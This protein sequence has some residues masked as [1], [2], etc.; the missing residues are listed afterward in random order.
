MKSLV[1]GAGYAGLSAATALVAAGRDVTVLEARDRVGGRAWSQRL[2]NGAVI[3]R[4]AEFIFPGE[5]TIRQ[6]AAEYRVPVLSHGVLYERRTLN[7][8][9]VSWDQLLEDEHLVLDTAQ[10]LAAD[11][12][13]SVEDAFKAA[14]GDGY[15]QNSYFRRY[16]TSASADPALV[17]VHSLL[18]PTS[19]PLIEDG[20]HMLGGNQALAIAMAA[21]LGERVHLSTPV[22]SI[23]LSSDQVS[24][25]TASGNRFS[26]D[27]LV[28]AVPLPLLS[29]LQWSFSLPPTVTTALAHRGMGD[30]TKCSVELAEDVADSARQF[31][32]E[33]SWTWQSQNLSAAAR[34]P[35]LTGFTGGL[36]AARYAGPGGGALWLEDVRELQGSLSTAGE[37]V[38]TAWKND[39]W[40]RGS[41]SHAIVGW[42]PADGKAFDEPIEGRITFAGEH[43]SATATLNGAAKSGLDAADRLLRAHR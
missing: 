5:H 41:Y 25:I 39:P 8:T 19:G 43:V 4:G 32:T 40:T 33:F 24:V 20:G 7:G 37:P 15:Q 42:N 13:A 18:R 10:G 14:F 3:E 21:S 29:E 31:S 6:L 26:A 23:E 30:A 28:V 34:V 9:R 11:A 38:V 17:S 35:A 1:I 2:D 22:T 12:T 36:S 16:A 27:E